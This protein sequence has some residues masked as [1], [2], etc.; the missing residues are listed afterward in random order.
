VASNV[1]TPTEPRL[2]TP[3]GL[4]RH[5][6]WLVSGGL[7]QSLVAFG[8]NLVLVRHVAPEGFGRFALQLAS[9]GLVLSILSLR[10]G[11]LVIRARAEG[12]TL[13][14]E[15]RDTYANAICQET[16]WAGLLAL[17]IM[18]ATGPVDPLGL[19]L[20]GAVLVQHLQTNLKA[21]RERSMAYR[22]LSLLETGSHFS[23]HGLSV[24]LV[25]TG[26]GVSALYARE[27]VI[28]LVGLGGLH[29]LGALPRFRWRWLGPSDWRRLWQEA[30]DVWLDGALESGLARVL[31]LAAGF[32]GGERGAGLF[33][34]AR[35]LAM[36]P[37]Q[38]LA[39]VAGR[40]ALNRFARS[41][42]VEERARGR[43]RLAL[44]L[45]PPLLVAA[46]MTVFLADPIVPWLLG[47]NWQD[48]TGLLVA[49]VGVV[50]GTSLLASLKM[51]LYAVRGWR[52]MLGARLLQFGALAIGL[53]IGSTSVA[54]ENA[55]LGVAWGV[56]IGFALA[57][58]WAWLGILRLERASR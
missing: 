39:P 26:A 32:A 14:D 21:F 50:V 48:T 29:A 31:V 12:A 34:Q 5:A 15:R 1:I 17:G 58:A 51:Y 36:V 7:V 35:R 41:Q 3:T 23:G 27:A 49:L 55:V 16:L 10:G 6:A 19:A 43:R 22:Q 9:V 30:R 11:T 25:L 38:F 24:L 8:A 20:I 18:L 42:D 4:G 13:D 46:V 33:F 37:H 54:P 47:E 57:V 45:C 56:S 44:W 53:A 2:A 28:A 52:L 40:L